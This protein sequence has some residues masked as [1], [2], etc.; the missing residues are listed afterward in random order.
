[1][2]PKVRFPFDFPL[3]FHQSE[4]KIRLGRADNIES[5]EKNFIDRY[6]EVEEHNARFKNGQESYE[7]GI[8]ELAMYSYEEL[9]AQ[10]TGYVPM[11]GTSDPLPENRR[12]RAAPASF[13]WTSRA[14]VVRPVQHQGSCGS[15]WAFAGVGAIEG[16][17]HAFD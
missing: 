4:F 6:T 17:E 3:S 1:M 11:N 12:G 15:C 14:G 10:K 9:L 8:N 7:M 16:N 13:T 5:L 2:R